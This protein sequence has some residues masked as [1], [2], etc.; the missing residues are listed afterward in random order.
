M[1]VAMPH[2]LGRPQTDAELTFSVPGPMP[3]WNELLDAKGARDPRTGKPLP[4]VYG[5]LKERW[6]KHVRNALLACNI[7]CQTEGA[8]R[9]GFTVYER[10]RRRDPLNVLGG[11]EKIIM[12]AL[13]PQKEKHPFTG[14]TEVVWAGVLTGD[15][16]RHIVGVDEPKW[17]VDPVNP[18]V[19]V[20]MRREVSPC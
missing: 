9:V 16:W 11:A 4:Y 18:R 20:R 6:H 3:G 2:R 14:A 15:G 8:W 5:A 10:D 13:L 12:D 19:V 7:A 1:N 17:Y